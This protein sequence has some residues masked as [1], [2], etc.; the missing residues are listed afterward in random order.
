MNRVHKLMSDGEFKRYSDLNSKA[1]ENRTFCRHSV[2]HSLDVARILYIIVLE[3]KIQ[4]KKDIIYAA[5]LLHDIGRYAQYEANL[6]HHQ[7]GATIGRVLLENNGFS[8]DE[9]NMICD[10]IMAHHTIE[11]DDNNPLKKLLYKADKLSRNCFA[12]CEYDN[13]YWEADLKN[14][15]IEY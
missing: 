14:T 11:V 9:I 12:C 10:A 13:C 5:A 8:E 2:E 3:E 1:E 15:K 7:V 4:I 6:S